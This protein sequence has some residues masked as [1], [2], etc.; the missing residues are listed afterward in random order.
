MKFGKGCSLSLITSVINAI[1]MEFAHAD[2]RNAAII[3]L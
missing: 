3:A 2:T 1:A